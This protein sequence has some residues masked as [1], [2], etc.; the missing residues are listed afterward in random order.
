MIKIF[1]SLS[2]ETYQKLI[3]NFLV[4]RPNYKVVSYLVITIVLANTLMWIMG[5]PVVKLTFVVVLWLLLIVYLFLI[6]NLIKYRTR[7]IYQNTAFLHQEMSFDFDKDKIIW[8]TSSG[9]KESAMESIYKIVPT[10]YA[11]IVSFSPYQIMPIPYSSISSEEWKNITSYINAYK[12]YK[13]TPKYYN[14]YQN[15]RELDA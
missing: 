12:K 1:V 6:P 7:I 13:L 3:T 4:T 8:T 10:P 2:E 5:V 11:L 9:T 15:K 14:D